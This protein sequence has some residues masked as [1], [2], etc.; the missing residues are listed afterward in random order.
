MHKVLIW[1]EDVNKLLLPPT[2]DGSELWSEALFSHDDSC[3][4]RIARLLDT[5]RHAVDLCVFT[6]T[7]DR[8]AGAILDAH[9]RGVALRVISDNDKTHDPGSDIGRL[10]RAGAPVRLD[11]TPHH[12]HHKFALFDRGTLLTGNYNWTRSAAE[13]NS[14]NLLVSND[15]RLVSA[16]AKEF[17]RLWGACH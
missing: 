8:I 14:E 2:T 15:R 12:M 9:R 13:C 16:F 3:V 6:I 1:L 17:E 10:R 7:D 4:R 11:R 5:A